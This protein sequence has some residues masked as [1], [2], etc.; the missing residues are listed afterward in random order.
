[1]Q[2]TSAL[3]PI[4]SLAFTTLL[5]VSAASE[6]SWIALQPGGSS[7]RVG[8]VA[9]KGHFG[10]LSSQQIADLSSESITL[11]IISWTENIL[12]DPKREEGEEDVGGNRRALQSKLSETRPVRCLIKKN[13][14][15][16]END[17]VLELLT[18]SLGTLI[19]PNSQKQIHC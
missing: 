17:G 13:L 4:C 15:G 12:P 2:S 1:M 5:F 7:M 3:Q 8:K 11:C 14:K 6:W 9:D 16:R 19:W 10:C 18:E